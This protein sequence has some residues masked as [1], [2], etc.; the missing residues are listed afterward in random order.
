[1]FQ[2]PGINYT[3][4]DYNALSPAESLGLHLCLPLLPPL[5]SLSET[6]SGLSLHSPRLAAA[7]TTVAQ[8]PSIT[9]RRWL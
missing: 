8:M 9:L 7:W 3:T 1:M 6:G 2:F 4:V 5:S